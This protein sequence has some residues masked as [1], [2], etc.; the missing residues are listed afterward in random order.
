L[1]VS[2]DPGAE[3][4]AENIRVRRARIDDKRKGKRRG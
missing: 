3:W 2:V 4:R 1:G